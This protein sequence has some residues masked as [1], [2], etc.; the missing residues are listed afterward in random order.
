MQ[1]VLSTW[2]QDSEH[3]HHQTLSLLCQ[4]LRVYWCWQT[5]TEKDKSGTKN[6]VGVSSAG[7][8]DPNTAKDLM[9][10]LE[11][12]YLGACAR[13]HVLKQFPSTSACVHTHTYMYTQHI[14]CHIP[15][16][17]QVYITGF[18]WLACNSNHFTTILPRF[19]GWTRWL[20][21]LQLQGSSSL[22][23]VD[24][25]EP[26]RLV[27]GGSQTRTNRRRKRRKKKRSQ[28]QKQ[29]LQPRKRPKCFSLKQF[30]VK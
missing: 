20:P 23:L 18:P 19:Q 15:H 21:R 5:T 26:Q 14:N 11:N 3:A 6:E 17:L 9:S 25:G 29:R 13:W 1:E 2:V 12:W 24:L 30:R 28:Y 27:L 22:V 7:R 4:E 8:V 10:F 16:S